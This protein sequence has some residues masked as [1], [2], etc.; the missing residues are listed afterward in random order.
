MVLNP[1][2]HSPVVRM[3]AAEKVSCIL[4]KHERRKNYL[5]IFIIFIHQQMHQ[6]R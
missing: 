3:G 1:Y 6:S 4:L 2:Q 5:F